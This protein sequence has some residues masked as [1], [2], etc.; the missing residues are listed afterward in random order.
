MVCRRGTG[1][2]SWPVVPSESQYRGTHTPHF[3]QALNR[4]TCGKVVDASTRARVLA[5]AAESRSDVPR[6]VEPRVGIVHA[7]LSVSVGSRGAPT[8]AGILFLSR[9]LRPLSSANGFTSEEFIPAFSFGKDEVMTWRKAATAATGLPHLGPH[10][11]PL[12][13]A[14]TPWTWPGRGSLIGRSPRRQRGASP[15]RAVRINRVL[16]RNSSSRT[17]CSG[18]FYECV[19]ASRHGRPA[20]SHWANRAPR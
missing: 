13:A 5:A 14:S 12:K 1:T 11:L 8:R 2:V 4:M 19:E 20:P 15:G 17:A 16:D 9:G 18:R 10:P 6:V 3:S 7:L